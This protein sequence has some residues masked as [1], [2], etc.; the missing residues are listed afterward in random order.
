LE[1]STTLSIANRRNRMITTPIQ[2][3]P[4]PY[5]DE[6]EDTDRG[7]GDEDV[8]SRPLLPTRALNEPVEPRNVTEE[9]VLHGRLPAI[10]LD[11]DTMDNPTSSAPS[12]SHVRSRRNAGNI[13]T[14]PSG[15][16]GRER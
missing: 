9:Y 16:G 2:E 13:P 4:I 3:M 6:S 14:L 1:M 11:D 10:D 7:E 5:D 15:R 8:E 12:N